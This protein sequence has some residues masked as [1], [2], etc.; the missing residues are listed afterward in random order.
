VEELNQV[1]D[2]VEK[3]LTMAEVVFDQVVVVVVVKQGV[4]VFI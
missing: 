3:E 2:L 1:P 4:A